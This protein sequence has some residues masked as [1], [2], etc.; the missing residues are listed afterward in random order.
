MIF[1]RTQEHIIK[2]RQIFSSKIKK[3]I[4][5][6]EDDMWYIDRGFFTVSTINRIIG[7][8]KELYQIL[9]ERGYSAEG[10]GFTKEHYSEGEF[11]FEENFFELFENAM[12]LE[13]AY[14]GTNDIIGKIKKI[15]HYESMNRLE[16]FL[17][18]LE[19]M[20]KGGEK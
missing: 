4:E 14:Y 1:D 20:L 9:E 2:S 19:I 17:H 16:K 3:G 5:L 8:I 11:F 18:D 6:T 13:R 10:F 7:K 12:I 15:Y